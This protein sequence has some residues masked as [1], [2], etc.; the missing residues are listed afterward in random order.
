MSNKLKKEIKSLNIS[1]KGA[2]SDGFISTPKQLQVI[3]T[4]DA[5]GKSISVHDDNTMFTIPFEP[6]ARYLK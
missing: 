5:F 2:V 4:N 3:I 6:I 1:V